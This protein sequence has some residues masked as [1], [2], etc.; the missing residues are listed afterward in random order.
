MERAKQ[1]S[2]CASYFLNGSSLEL[3][4]N[5]ISVE[6]KENYLTRFFNNV[7]IL[8]KPLLVKV[9]FNP[10]KKKKITKRYNFKQIFQK[11][12]FPSNSHTRTHKLHIENNM[13][14]H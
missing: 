10:I 1:L 6:K 14:R 7:H 12:T 4:E 3:I 9:S 13:Q 2:T 11:I 5:S 8:K